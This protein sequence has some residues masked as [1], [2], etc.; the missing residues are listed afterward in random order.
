M[1]VTVMHE[2]EHKLMKVFSNGGNKLVDVYFHVV[3]D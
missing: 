2:H 1:I 3:S